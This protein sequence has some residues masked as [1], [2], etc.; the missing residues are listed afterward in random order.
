MG[1]KRSTL[2][3]E[4]ADPEF[5]GLVVS[6]KRLS[7][8]QALEMDRLA[9]TMGDNSVHEN[10]EQFIKYL[11]D[12]IISWNLEDDDDNPIPHTYESLMQQDLPLIMAI[13]SAWRMTATSVPAPLAGDSESGDQ[14]LAESL[15]MEGS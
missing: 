10:V 5:D 13:G 9:A 2:V 4:F 15:P 11:A 7:V 1:F 12:G 8:G 3:L 14:S 6:A